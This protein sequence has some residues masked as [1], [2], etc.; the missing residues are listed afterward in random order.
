MLRVTPLV[1][2]ATLILPPAIIAAVPGSS[3]S[4]GLLIS[5][6][7]WS[8]VSLSTGSPPYSFKKA[9]G[10]RL[11]LVLCVIG[12][13]AVHAILSN[14]LIGGADFGRLSVSCSI[15][16]IEC[17]AALLAA[18]KLLRVPDSIPIRSANAALIFLSLTGIAAIAGVPAIGGVPYAK[19]V[20]FFAEPSHFALAFLPMLLISVGAARRTTQ[21]AAI[22]F[23]LAL[24]ALLENL[25]M[26]VGVLVIAT[27]LLRGMAMV[28]M[29]LTLVAAAATLDF[30]YY[31]N[32][33]DFTSDTNN[34]SALVFMQG[35]ENALLNFGETHGLGV[36]FQQFGIAGSKGDITEKIAALLGG[37]YIN[38][39]DG[40]STATKLVAE[41]G[42]FGILMIIGYLVLAA[43][44]MRFIRQQQRL[45]PKGRD[46]RGLFFQSVIVTYLFEIFIRGMGYFS[47]GGFLTLTA[48]LALATRRATRPPW[49]T[50][51]EPLATHYAGRA[52][53]AT[54][55]IPP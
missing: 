24:A 13:L 54:G 47:A 25:T 9:A 12:V 15:L 3:I 37:D 35:W 51:A 55:T 28:M 38:L 43:R 11:A 39:L 40:G 53:A 5:A 31:S 44:A 45:P 14:M 20:V 23:A 19:G 49:L 33:L 30:T 4:S 26:V 18:D 17:I 7:L 29:V 50:A 41:F 1:L 46:W 8:F 6:L 21:L 52:R 16:L 2:I 27:L 22:T 34:I 32:R 42:V 36:G 48:L 10:N